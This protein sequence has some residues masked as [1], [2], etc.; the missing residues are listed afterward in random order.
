LHKARPIAPGCKHPMARLLSWVGR[1]W[2]FLLRN[3]KGEHCIVHKTGDVPK[4]LD[5]MATRMRDTR[6]AGLGSCNT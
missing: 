3:L 6:E 4:I 2:S 1:A 5:E